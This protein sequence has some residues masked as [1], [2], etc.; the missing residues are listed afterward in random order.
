MRPISRQHVNKGSSA[1]SFRHNVGRS[2]AINFAGPMR[3]GI[4]L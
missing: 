1:R 3:G 4:R 2:K